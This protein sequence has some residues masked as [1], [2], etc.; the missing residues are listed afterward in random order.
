MEKLWKNTVFYKLNHFLDNISTRRYNNLLLGCKTDPILILELKVVKNNSLYYFLH[1]SSLY[2]PL[3]GAAV[4][5]FLK[6]MA[7]KKEKL[8]CSGEFSVHK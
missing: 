6:E 5:L 2:S 1:S 4:A 7:L 3:S 8:F